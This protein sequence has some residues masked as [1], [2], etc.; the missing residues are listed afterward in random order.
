[1]QE[2]NI[3]NQKLL[4]KKRVTLAHEHFIQL[5]NNYFSKKVVG[6]FCCCCLFVCFLMLA[7]YLTFSLALFLHLFLRFYIPNTLFETRAAGLE[8]VY[9]TELRRVLLSIII[10]LCCSPAP[11]PPNTREAWSA[12]LCQRKLH[13]CVFCC[14]VLC[15]VVSGQQNRSSKLTT[16]HPAGNISLLGT[17]WCITWMYIHFYYTLNGLWPNKSYWSLLQLP[18][19]FPVQ[20][21]SSQ[22]CIISVN[23]TAPN[24]CPLTNSSQVWA[25]S[26][27]LGSSG[28][29]LS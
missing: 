20:S 7:R 14:L 18:L 10:K 5:Q 6:I 13:F 24:C 28:Q 19:L 4:G 16:P 11:H 12:I 17:R 23:F 21:R 27:L 25:C 8:F 26:C 22:S 2:R 9:T 29:E 3:K 1:M 15:Q